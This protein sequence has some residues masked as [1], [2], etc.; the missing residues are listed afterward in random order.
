M[1]TKIKYLLFD[2]GG[3]IVLGRT[4]ESE[5]VNRTLVSWIKKKKKNYTICALTNNTAIL[6]RLLKKKFKIY[7]IF[8][9]IFNSAEMGLVKPNPKFFKY[10]L[11]KLKAKPK[12]CLFIDNNP[13]NI[14]AAKKI[15]FSVILFLTNKDFLEKIKNLILIKF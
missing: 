13:E 2:I 6:D 8:D 9:H 14:K 5:R 4:F 11:K 10:T 7:Y 3:V 15:G 12:E 1:K